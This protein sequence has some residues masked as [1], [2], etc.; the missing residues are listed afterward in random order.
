MRRTPKARRPGRVPLGLPTSYRQDADSLGDGVVPFFESGG[1]ANYL[2]IGGTQFAAPNAVQLVTSVYVPPGR[3]GFVKQ[4]RVAPRIP[5]VFADGWRGVALNFRWFPGPDGARP[6]GQIGV[7][8][9]PMAWESYTVNPIEYAIGLPEWWW[10]LTLVQGTLAA[11]RG[12]RAP[13]DP[14]DFSTQYL[15][16][17][18]AVDAQAYGLGL[19]A[20]PIT[21]P[22]SSP[23]SPFSRQK[24][25]ILQ[26]DQLSFH[27]VVPPD[28]TV[29]LFARWQQD[30][31]PALS[32][33][34]SD[35][36][37]ISAHG[38]PT[39]P[40]WPAFGSL[41]GY[42]QPTTTDAAIANTRFGWGG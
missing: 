37:A 30:K 32:V 10:S 28:H 16:P 22:G 42:T 29:C 18:L 6:A 14:L 34:A 1:R 7:W 9:T 36:E 8:E 13:F 23:G 38:V 4:I 35:P 11:A 12:Q 15:I 39:F 27:V 3:V 21:L 17:E 33:L 5:P 41:L 31:F 2:E 19:A 24:M 25:Q 26:G 20:A 40:L